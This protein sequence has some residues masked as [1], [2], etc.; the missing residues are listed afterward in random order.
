MCRISITLTCNSRRARFENVG[1]MNIRLDEVA[2][3]VARFQALSFT[4]R[5]EITVAVASCLLNKTVVLLYKNRV[6]MLFIIVHNMMRHIG[7][8]VV[9]IN[10]NS[11]VQ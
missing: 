1:H 3:Q 8:Y 10:K 9:I 6:H 4:T 5:S 2:H 7:Y 11:R